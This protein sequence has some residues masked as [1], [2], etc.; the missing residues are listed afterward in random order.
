MMRIKVDTHSHTIASCDAYST[1][2]EMAKAGAEA[3]LEALAITEHA[4]TMPETCGRFYFSNLGVIPRE[5]YGIKMMFGVELNILDEEGNVDLPENLLQQMDLVIAS[6]HPPC[7]GESR[8]M[9]EN[10]KAYINAMKNPYVQII[11]HPDDGRFPIDYEKLVAVAK[12]TGTLLEVNNSSL[13]PGGFRMG[14]R[15]NSLNLLKL[16]KKNGV[17]ITTGSDSHVDVDVAN[18]CYINEV[19]RE[20]DFP[21]DLVVTTSYEK[22]KRHLKQWKK[23]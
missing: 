12:E 11:G 16:C 20:C 7:Y 2:R 5:M 8:G 10:T 14:T 3:G 18:F 9:E 4:P 19:L 21:E 15:E 13:T 1:I 17:Y 23:V 6:V 22:F